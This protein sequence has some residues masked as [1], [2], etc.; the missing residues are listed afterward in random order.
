MKPHNSSENRD[1]V[2]VG[3]LSIALVLAI[4]GGMYWALWVALAV[5]LVVSVVE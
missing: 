4:F 1:L 3:V 2:S 5:L